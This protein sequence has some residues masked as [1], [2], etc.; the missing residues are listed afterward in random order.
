MPTYVLA[1]EYL[2]L[3]LVDLFQLTEVEIASATS[4][5][6]IRLPPTSQIINGFRHLSESLVGAELDEIRVS[7][8]GRVKIGNFPLSLAKTLF[9][10]FGFFILL[11]LQLT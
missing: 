3:N 7:L 1:G 8:V 5:K 11:L 4:Q 9:F 6:S 10:S 2:E